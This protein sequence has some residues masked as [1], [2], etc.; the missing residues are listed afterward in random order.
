[1]AEQLEVVGF[2]LACVAT[3]GD[4][5]GGTELLTKQVLFSFR[6]RLTPLTIEVEHRRIDTFSIVVRIVRNKKQNF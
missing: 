2:H 6:P 3:A 4:S 5:F 1:M